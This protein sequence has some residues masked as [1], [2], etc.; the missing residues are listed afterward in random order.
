LER[1]LK[2][3]VGDNAAS[4]ALR[5]INMQKLLTTTVCVL[6]LSTAGAFAQSSQGK[7]GSDNGPISNSAASNGSGS[8]AKGPT[9]KPQRSGTANQVTTGV[10]KN[11]GGSNSGNAGPGNGQ[12][13][14]R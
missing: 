7:A 14:T 5:E 6:A 13:S 9:A 12:P 10:A 8:L 1:S 3:F 11:A 4:C 2:K